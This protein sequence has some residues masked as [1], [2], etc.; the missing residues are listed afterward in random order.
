MLVRFCILKRDPDSHSPQ[1]IFQAAFE[2]RDNDRLTRAEEEWLERELAWLRMHLPVPPCLR[3][4]GN[5]RA[6]CWFKP[7]ARRP[8]AKVRSIVVLLQARDV[9]VEMVTTAE[10]DTIIYEDQ[11]QVVAKPPRKHRRG[12][13]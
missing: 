1:G 6:I 9:A 7:Q 3:Q 2:L 5:D 11:W 13:R 10:P 12:R 8:I 4:S